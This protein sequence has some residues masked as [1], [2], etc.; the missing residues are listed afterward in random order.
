[1]SKARILELAPGEQWSQLHE[2]VNE[3]LH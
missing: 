3:L 2:N 1:M